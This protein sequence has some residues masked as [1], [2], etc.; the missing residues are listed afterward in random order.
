MKLM[1]IMVSSTVDI[2]MGNN[3]GGTKRH[4]MLY[5][6]RKVGEGRR[7]VGER[8]EGVGEG[9]RGVG[10]RRKGVGEGRKVPPCP[11]PHRCVSFFY[12]FTSIVR[13]TLTLKKIA[14]NRFQQEA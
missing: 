3:T 8:R 10:E 12:Y 5:L 7:G 11:P 2:C 1:L 13:R 6:E 4:I 14:D 9:R